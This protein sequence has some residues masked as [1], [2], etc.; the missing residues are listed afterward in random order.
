MSDSAGRPVTGIHC[1]FSSGRLHRVGKGDGSV[2]VGAVSVGVMS[3]LVWSVWLM[4]GAS[5]T[6]PICVVSAL[7]AEMVCGGWEC[8][9]SW[10]PRCKWS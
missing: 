6:L 4:T 2:N 1:A 10:T 5:D 7:L 8:R 3:T 9:C